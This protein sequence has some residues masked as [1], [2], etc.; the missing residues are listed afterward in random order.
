MRLIAEWNAL[1][2]R[3]L[4]EKEA[5]PETCDQDEYHDPRHEPQGILP[6]SISRR[7]SVQDWG[8]D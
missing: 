7:E 5:D 8:Q 6:F 1:E 2:A 4:V 3:H